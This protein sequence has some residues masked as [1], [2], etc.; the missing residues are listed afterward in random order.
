[1]AWRGSWLGTRAEPGL[2]GLKRD[3]LQ[4][5]L[6]LK[7]TEVTPTGTGLC[8]EATIQA[9]NEEEKKKR[10]IHQL[11]ELQPHEVAL[12]VRLRKDPLLTKIPY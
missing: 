11:L 5:P 7:P 3:L 10:T 4:T 12:K 2:G 8:H 9:K 1:M 6:Y